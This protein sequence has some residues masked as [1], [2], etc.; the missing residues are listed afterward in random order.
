MGNFKDKEFDIVILA[1]QSNA[2]GNG[3]RIN[4]EPLKI[5]DKVFQVADKNRAAIDSVD[6]KAV[7]AVTMP[8]ECVVEHA[9]DRSNGE[10]VYADLSGTFANFYA[11]NDLK[12]GRDLLIVK[13]AV[14]G[15]G[16]A[17]EQWG[18][19]KPLYERM[20][21]MT[22]FALSLGKNNKIVAVLW[23]QGEHDAFENAQLS[24]K[25]IFDFYVDKF[26]AQVKD[27]RLR[28]GNFKLITG[29]FVNDWADKN[30]PQTGAV[31]KALDFVC[32]E[33]GNAC[34]VSSEG[35]LSNDQKIHN[36]DDIHFCAESV[37]ELGTRY[38]EAFKK[39]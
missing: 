19:G 17:R 3:V 18:I 29:E 24:E 5:S 7:I 14:G 13:T 25:E 21:E 10:F 15:S 37:E 35:L 39:I 23:H 28:Y 30:Q 31:E 32:K 33:V 4:S 2:E 20:V 6:G 34:L 16:F 38:Y 1:G 12:S 27:M 9:H 11:K 22:D 36:G 26:G 8:T